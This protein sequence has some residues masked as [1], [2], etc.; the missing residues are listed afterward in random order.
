MIDCRDG[1]KWDIDG[2]RAFLKREYGNGSSSAS[3]VSRR[4]RAFTLF[5]Q[6]GAARRGAAARR[7]PSRPSDRCSGWWLRDLSL[8]APAAADAPQQVQAAPLV[9]KL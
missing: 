1:K 2:V 5:S 9:C 3:G 4:G 6:A 7:A 8:F